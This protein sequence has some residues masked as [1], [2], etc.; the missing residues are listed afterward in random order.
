MINIQDLLKKTILSE[1]DNSFHAISFI[2]V[3]LIA[4]HIAIFYN[5]YKFSN[6]WIE[7]ES[8]KTTFILSHNA[9]EKIIPQPIIDKIGNY[10]EINQNLFSYEIFDKELIQ[11]S[12]G[13]RNVD[14][15]FGMSLPFVF[16]IKT[17][18]ENVIDQVYSKIL[19]LS[20]NRIIEKYSH[21]DQLFEVTS[22]FNRIKL[23]IFSMFLVMSVLLAFLILNITRAA[24]NS[25]Y[26]LLE[27]IQIM[28]ES[29]FGLSKN[30]SLSIIKKII[31]GAILSIIFVSFVS[32]L[33]IKMFGVNFYFFS[34][35]LYLEQTIKTFF[36][37]VSF[38]IILLFLLLIFL[39]LYLY[40]FFEKRFFDYI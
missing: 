19:E 29:S 13:I 24:L 25:N 39:M 30:I 18:E 32:S 37:L 4:L 20:N 40:Y 3:S 2:I 23:I 17:P 12:L 15:I 31:P 28:G 27:M 10:L 11:E 34:E 7:G 33:L 38:I 6:N 26:K 8:E 5:F 1:K 22:V 16:F 14:D 9:N 36:L 21:K 35:S